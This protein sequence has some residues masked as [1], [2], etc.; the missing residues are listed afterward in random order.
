MRRNYP[1]PI[2][3]YRLPDIATFDRDATGD[4]IYQPKRANG[5]RRDISPQRPAKQR[6]FRGKAAK[7][8]PG[9]NRASN[10]ETQQDSA[11]F[12]RSPK[13][14]SIN[15]RAPTQ[16]TC[17]G[18]PPERPRRRGRDGFPPRRIPQDERTPAPQRAQRGF[19]HVR[20]RAGEE[21]RP[22]P[23]GSKATFYYPV[24]CRPAETPVTVE[25]IRLMYS[26]F[27]SSAISSWFMRTSRSA[28]TWAM[29]SAST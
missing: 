9:Q 17:A 27:F 8:R 2:A 28:R 21:T 19:F 4:R 25:R 23:G 1:L 11:P 29:E 15:G 22:G 12:G 6:A 16:P 24:F 7:Q 13:Q 5:I 18:N 10:Y 14:R 20:G 26:A 3:I